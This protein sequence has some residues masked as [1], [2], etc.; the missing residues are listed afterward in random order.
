VSARHEPVLVAEVLSFLRN[1]EGLYLDATL[2]DG[3]HAE[4]LLEAEPGARLLGC[5]RD[6]A[7]LETAGERLK[8]FE[9]RV[10]LRHATFSEVPAALDAVGGERLT[11][12][13]FDL[14]V[15]SRQIDDPARGM[16]FMSEG[17]LDLRMDPGRGRSAAERL[18]GVDEQEL[19]AVLRE[20]GDVTGAARIAR[21]LVAEAARGGLKTTRSL[22]DGI[23][24]AL[25]GRPHPRRYAQIF[26]ALRIW[27]N[28]EAAEL[29]AALRWLPERMRPGGVVVTLAYHSGEDRRIKRA[30]RGARDVRPSRRL[31]E[32]PGDRAP[33][34]PWDELNHRVVT[35]TPNEK[36]T[37]P[38]ARSAR[39]RAFRRKKS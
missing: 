26:Q 11:G 34:S 32:I 19:A 15:S 12:A 31:P 39:L 7:A 3:G 38:R 14:G 37:N 30:L 20:H 9:R 4:A 18:S 17:P 24:R 5:A 28:D 29:E 16:S 27:V 13:L 8:R 6:R 23:D 25:G 2:G 10:T 1:G 36:A 21:A 33:E 22:T 35:P